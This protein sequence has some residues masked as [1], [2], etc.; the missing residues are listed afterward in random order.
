MK[1]FD[2][3]EKIIREINDLENII[4]CRLVVKNVEIFGTERQHWNEYKRDTASFIS[5]R[6]LL[7]EKLE[8]LAK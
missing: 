4:K 7:V 8:N 1:K 2:T 6:D 3:K 5:Q